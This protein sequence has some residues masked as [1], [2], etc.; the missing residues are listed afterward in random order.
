MPGIRDFV[1]TQAAPLA[2]GPIKAGIT[3][4]MTAYDTLNTERAK[5]D[6]NPNYSPTGKRTETQKFI[7]SNL[8]EVV[9][10]TK[11]AEKMKAK[12]A[13]KRKKLQPPAIDKTDVASAMLRARACDRLE[14]MGKGERKAFLAST[15]D[16]LYLAAVLE[17]PND[18]IGGIDAETREMVLAKSIEIAHP[19]ALAALEREN[20]SVQML[21][22]AARV[23]AEHAAEIAGLPNVRAL[24]ELIN[25]AIP[26]QRHLEADAERIVSAI[27]A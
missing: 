21:D 4:A 10:V 14:K 12:Q 9:R 7:R 18:M 20:Q 2:D 17:A 27:A 26:D 3:R 23:L 24:D 25:T 6:N 13:E 11:L 16:P 1:V 19:G 8:H 22:V 5:V 15:S